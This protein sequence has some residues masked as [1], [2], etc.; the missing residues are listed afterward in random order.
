MLEIKLCHIYIH[1]LFHIVPYFDINNLIFIIQLLIK[2][3]ILF[4]IRN[5]NKDIASP[6]AIAST[7]RDFPWIIYVQTPCH[8]VQCTVPLSAFLIHI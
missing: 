8:G 6:F 5:H 4:S 7:L 3:Y 2:I 1:P